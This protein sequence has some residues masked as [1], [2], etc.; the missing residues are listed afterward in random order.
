MN[1]KH[2]SADKPKMRPLD[3][4]AVPP[5]A[6]ELLDL[7]QEKPAIN[8]RW[9]VRAIQYAI[10]Y[11][12]KQ[13]NNFQKPSYHHPLE[14]AKILAPFTTDQDTFVA[15]LL[16]GSVEATPLSYAQIAFMFNPTVASLVDGVTKF[17]DSWR[18]HALEDYEVC[19][20][21]TH[22][23]QDDKRV[24]QIKVADRVH[25][26]R[27]IQ[28]YPS[29]TQRKKL[30]EETLRVFLPLSQNI[31]LPDLVQELEWLSIYTLRRQ[32]KNR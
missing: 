1:K 29:W 6:Q 9:I 28:S 2:T 26:M 27:T 31:G 19:Y 14:V 30:A 17:K 20:K 4:P 22:P 18:R 10:T 8:L 24:L 12:R 5:K 15:V 3:L 32:T 7:L 16:Y 23:Q 11:H 13:A 21:L 25:D